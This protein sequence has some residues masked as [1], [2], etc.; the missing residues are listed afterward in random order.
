LALISGFVNAVGFVM[1]GSFTSHVTGNFARFANDL[2]LREPTASSALA[3]VFAFLLGATVASVMLESA[4]FRT[5]PQAYGV[6]LLLEAALLT[7]VV[8]VVTRVPLTLRNIDWETAALCA[9]MGMQ[10]SLVTRISGAVVRTTHLTGVLTDIG[11]EAARW[12]RF[13]RAALSR[14]VGIP[15]VLSP[16]PERPSAPKIILLATIMVSFGIGALAGAYAATAFG[17][18]AL[19]APVLALVVAAFLAFYSD[20]RP[21]DAK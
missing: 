2:A 9:A 3:M 10:N 16:T 18:L 5:T 20:G 7:V 14:R 12:F 17:Q 21:S 11:I 6:A 13:W 8:V 15:L 19:L 1:L 4:V